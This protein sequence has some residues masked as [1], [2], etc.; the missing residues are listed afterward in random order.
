MTPNVPFERA[1]RLGSGICVGVAG[2]LAFL[3]QLSWITGQWML[4]TLGLEYVPMAPSTAGATLLLSLSVLMSIHRPTRPISTWFC[5]FS[6]VYAAVL[7]VLALVSPRLSLSMLFTKWVLPVGT[8][9]A[10]VPVGIMSPFTAV[11]LLVCALALALETPP[12][13]SS[14]TNR[15]IASALAMISG[16]MNFLVVLSYVL[17]APILYGTSTIPMAMLSGVALGL[18]SVGLIYNSAPDVWP[19][20]TIL[21][22]HS[23]EPSQWT[24]KGPMAAFLLLLSAIAVVGGFYLEVQ[25]TNM[26]RAAQAELEAVANLKTEEI[27]NWRK[28]RLD[29]AY[30]F[31]GA[32]FVSR[33]VQELF[34]NPDAETARVEALNWLTLLKGGER[35][36][37]A[38]IFDAGGSVRLSIPPETGPPDSEV[39]TRVADTVKKNAINL[40]DLHGGEGDD[41]H[42]DLMV[43]VHAPGTDPATTAPMAVIVLRVDPQQFLFPL[44]QSWPSASPTAETLLVRREDN[45][46]LY[47]NELR[48]R[49]GAAMKLRL[50]LDR[51]NYPAAMAV[52]GKVGLA[53][54]VDYR[55]VPVVTVLR[56]VPD[57]PW[58]LVAK[59]DQ[60]EIYAAL[61]AQ[62][63]HVAA[64][65]ALLMLV[66]G[67]GIVVLW[68]QRNLVYYRVTLGQEKRQTVLAQRFEHLMRQ[69][70]DLILL[71]GEDGKIVEANDRAVQAYGRSQAELREIELE[72]LHPPENRAACQQKSEDLKRNGS[73]LFEAVQQRADGSTFPVE[74]SA[75]LVDIG[76]AEH[77]LYIMRDITERRRAEEQL[78]EAQQRLQLAV[79]GARL[80]FWDWDFRTNAVYFSR[81]YKR[82]L[83]YKDGE[84]SDAFQ[85]WE[86]NLHPDDREWTLAAVDEFIKNR[87]AYQEIE[88]RLR[89]RDGSY[90]WILSR[91]VLQYGPAG[92]PERMIGGHIDITDRKLA[93]EA[94]RRSEANLIL[95]ERIAHVGYWERSPDG[96]AITWSD[97]AYRVF[98]LAPQ[99][100]P[101]NL[102]SFLAMVH[103]ED[104]DAV[105]QAIRAAREEDRPYNIEYRIVRPDGVVRFVHS[106]GELFLDATGR[107]D[108]VFGTMLDITESKRAAASLQEAAQRW[109]STFDAISDAIFVLDTGGVVLQCNRAAAE[110]LGCTPHEMLGRACYEL[111][112]GTQ[113]P[114]PECPM[115]AMLIAGRHTAGEM[116]RN[117]RWY[118]ITVDPVFNVQGTLIG[119]VHVMTDITERKN[120]EDALR[121]SEQRFRVIAENTGDVIWRL[122]TATRRFTYISPSVQRLRG[123]TPEEAM[124]QDITSALTPE[125]Y[126]K[127]SRHILERVAAFKA[128]DESARIMMQEIEQPHKDGS[129]LVT[130]VVS[131]LLTDA[132]GAIT[133]ILG[134]TRDITARKRA[135]DALRDSEQRFRVI[136][137]NTGDVIWRLDTATRRFTY[138][139]PSVQRLRGFTPEEAMGQDITSAL[140]PESFEKLGKSLLERMAAFKAGD[141]SAR[142]MM[143]EVEQ[144]HKNGSILTTEV[145]STLLMDAQ[146][147]VTEI[148]GVTR[149]ITARKRAEK[150]LLESEQRFRVIAENTGDVIWQLDLASLRFTYVSPSV[151]R[152]RGY[153]P[154]EVMAQPLEESLTPDSFLAVSEGIAAH[155]AEPMDETR[156]RQQRTSI[157]KQP[158]KDGS[159]VI[160]EVVT[161]ALT[162][163][164]GN[165]TGVLGVTRDITERMRA[166]EALR[167]SEQRFRAT[168]EDGLFGMVLCSL[169]GRF[170][171][172]NP[173]ICQM[174]G[175]SEPELRGRRFSDITLPDDLTASGKM[176]ERLMSG[177][178]DSFELEK[179][180][181]HKQGRTVWGVVKT[182]LLRNADGS[183]R[184]L[185]AQVQDITECKKAEQEILAN[186]DRLKRAQ[187]V[188]HIGSWEYDPNTRKI[189]GSEEAY[190]ILGLQ[191]AE[192]NLSV[193]I[194]EA[195]ILDW[196]GVR[197]AMRRQLGARNTCDVEFAMNPI[198]GSPQKSLRVVAELVRDDKGKA[199]KVVGVTEDITERKRLAETLRETQE[200]LQLALESSG[201]GT[202]DWMIS[203]GKAVWDGNTRRLFGFDPDSP[204]RMADQFM[205][206]IHPEDRE[207]I[208]AELAHAV[209]WQSEVDSEFRMIWRDGSM[210]DI[211]ARGKVYRDTANRAVRMTGIC[212]DISARKGAEAILKAYSDRLELMVEERTQQLRNAQDELVRKGKLAVLGQ[213]AGGVGH[214]LRNPL[215]VISNAVYFLKLINDSA[216]DTSKEYLNIISAE[217]Y[218]SQKIISDLLGFART[219]RSDRSAVA[220]PVLVTEVLA[221]ISPSKELE[222]VMDIPE[223]LPLLSVDPGQLKQVLSNLMLNAC[224]AMPGGGVLTVGAR[225]EKDRVW[226]SITDTGCG[227]SE[228]ELP[229]IFEPLYSTKARGF[230][231]GLSVTKNLV[232]ANEG[233]IE[234]RSEPGKGST[235]TV[236]LPAQE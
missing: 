48:H 89:H 28:E 220:L 209:Q 200:H 106:Q 59:V 203:A 204:V 34:S 120:W 29:D 104:R 129:I 133:E 24:A 36:A 205:A 149:D 49:K 180:Y 181:L 2:V 165:V 178:V 86:Q 103:P 154:E 157:V 72:V 125:S 216:D 232:E 83:G 84:F 147:T 167:A 78:H 62:A 135:E 13:G 168:F 81:E 65:M 201:V 7:S 51:P 231:L 163:E 173:A 3:V 121:D 37:C 45:D 142:I 47:L 207:R 226:V 114:V 132:Q 236:I 156:L 44:V 215:G 8:Q 21:S 58:F 73:I 227:M 119:A 112:H 214:E 152:L 100:R 18:L 23:A 164:R 80:G 136:A 54:G 195:R 140:T 91:A 61:H 38:A 42:L 27:T 124:G 76:G 174:L 188:G 60:A 25:Q 128:G 197:H 63:L 26:R 20:S 39:R 187:A 105:A 223:D 117:G 208:Y 145:V 144:P 224:Q 43:P 199:A 94:L 92:V 186:Q 95:A 153:T 127:L 212:W 225:C 196:D 229:L 53:E 32:A 52:L 96:D 183:P 113:C 40:T 115:S 172:V 77:R 217:V 109:R 41:I 193:D 190:R 130:E 111:V 122:D 110:L 118:A 162:D 14:R 93:E 126:E 158:C 74:V 116:P 176:V 79:E 185:L 30:F 138:I 202:W 19:I 134:V 222:V 98:G 68:R 218:N 12:F 57:S 22:D 141:E 35:Y 101:M 206:A 233:V 97:E 221:Q 192:G 228:E 90:R 184:M 213:L 75:R 70:N 9:V 171:E 33:D 107:P 235:F 191:P 169:D 148:L 64:V 189:W 137:E 159:V 155:F 4:G 46:V 71:V 88:F 161:T 123:F 210:H 179:R 1:I 31:A 10:G 56:K 16:L 139:S 102:A 82:Q 198:D 151:M 108:R 146:G 11:V 99:E 17:E 230:G 166:E 69:A 194:V 170:T 15:Q 234:V 211:S 66:S 150:A 50:P 55:G 67:L 6:I 177:A 131:T 219:S 143:Q 175:Y 5:W 85:H 87:G 160:T 182:R